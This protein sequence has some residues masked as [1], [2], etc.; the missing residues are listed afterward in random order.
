MASDRY[1]TGDE[2]RAMAADV[3]DDATVV[4]HAGLMWIT[5]SRRR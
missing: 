4:G 1:P 5:A 2:W 3:L